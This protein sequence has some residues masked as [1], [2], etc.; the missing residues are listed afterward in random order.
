MRKII[1]SVATSFDG[2]IE[3]PNREIDWLR[4]SDDTL[5][6]DTFKVLNS[7]LEEIDTI[8]YGRISYEAW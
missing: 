8:I 2:Y 3:G 6:K 5:Q 7:F 4:G 1:L